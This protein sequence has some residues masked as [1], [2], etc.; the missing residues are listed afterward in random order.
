MSKSLLYYSVA[1]AAAVAG[2]VAATVFAQRG[3]EEAAL[4]AQARHTRSFGLALQ[5]E[6]AR[7]D[8]REIARSRGIDAELVDREYREL[9]DG[10]ITLDQFF[11]RL[12]ELGNS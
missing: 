12:R 3:R 8:L 1:G 6:F 4:E 7:E 9:R 10:F 2:P 11:A 5:N